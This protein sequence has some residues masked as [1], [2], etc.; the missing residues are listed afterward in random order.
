M[1]RTRVLALCCAAIIAALYVVALVSGTEVR[2][3]VQTA[4]VWAGVILGWRRNKWAGW[5]AL[6]IFLFWLAAMVM[7][8]LFLLGWA[9]VISGHFSPAEVAMT[10]VIGA[11]S[12]A[13]IGAAVRTPENLSKIGVAG[14]FFL[15]AALQ[16]AAFR[17]S[18]LPGIAT[19]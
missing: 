17:V 19:R 18:L 12:V 6:P 7:I 2:H 1:I 3:V 8:W 11:A 13:G 4:P 9:R 15:G 16:F 5:L 14:L 10:I